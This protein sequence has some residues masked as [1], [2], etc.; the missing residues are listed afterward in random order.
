MKEFLPKFAELGRTMKVLRRLSQGEVPQGKG[1]RSG[2]IYAK[3]DG[4]IE[5]FLFS[6][7]LK[8]GS[9]QR[10]FVLER[11][12]KEEVAKRIFRSLDDREPHVVIRVGNAWGVGWITGIPDRMFKDRVVPSALVVLVG[13]K[14]AL[15]GYTAYG[16]LRSVEGNPVHTLIEKRKRGHSVKVKVAGRNLVAVNKGV[17]KKF[18]ESV[19]NAVRGSALQEVEVSLVPLSERRMKVGLSAHV[20]GKVTGKEIGAL[21]ELLELSG[22]LSRGTVPWAEGEGI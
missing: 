6:M 16:V 10:S 5:P 7:A 3:N 13:K 11:G 9:L 14:T 12:N 8:G 21:I 17:S 22:A 1:I 20:E 15:L 4:D 18:T 2:E 19:L